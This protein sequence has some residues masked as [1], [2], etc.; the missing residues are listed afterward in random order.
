MENKPYPERRKSSIYYEDRESKRTYDKFYQSHLKD[1]QEEGTR[2]LEI[3]HTKDDRINKLQF[4]CVR[5]EHCCPIGTF[6]PNYIEQR[7]AVPEGKLRSAY[8][9]AERE[10][11]F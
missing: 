7:S 2:T 9:I 11:F 8:K 1:E 4:S 3:D 6:Y 5:K 10:A